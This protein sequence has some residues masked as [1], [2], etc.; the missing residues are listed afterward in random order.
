MTVLQEGSL[1]MDSVFDRDLEDKS[2]SIG[3]IEDSKR[4]IKSKKGGPSSS[5]KRKNG[6]NKS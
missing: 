6:K 2:N 4:S 3:L 1:H 5:A